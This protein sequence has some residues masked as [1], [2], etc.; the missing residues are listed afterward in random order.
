MM[1]S[2]LPAQPAY[3]LARPA[4]VHRR[5]ALPVLQAPSEHSSL[6]ILALVVVANKVGISM[7]TNLPK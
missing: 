1:A 5:I 2:I 6:T 3:T 4:G 7:Y